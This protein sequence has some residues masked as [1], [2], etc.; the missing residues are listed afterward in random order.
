MENRNKKLITL[1][2]CALFVAVALV[3][4]LFKIYEMP[5]GGSIK[6][7]MLPLI[8]I[9]L[10]RGVKWGTFSSLVYL[11]IAIVLGREAIFY[12]GST[13]KVIVMCI[14]F[15]YVLAYAVIGLAPVIAKQFKNRVLGYSVA[16]F[17]VCFI[18]FLSHFI[19]GITIWADM[20]KGTKGMIIYS[21]VYNGTYMLPIAIVCVV[22]V[23][24]LAKTA[25]RIFQ[26]E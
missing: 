15:D 26:P 22:A 10:R 6:L 23:A 1:V 5:Y 19:S 16:T 2:E 14:I 8:I 20:T 13:L 11:V 7:V 21:I 17:A 3:L 9:A 12:P 25:P 18:R 4:D 24:L